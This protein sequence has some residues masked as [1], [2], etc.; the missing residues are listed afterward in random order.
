VVLHKW[1]VICLDNPS[2]KYEQRVY[3]IVL[4]IILE[5]ILNKVSLKYLEHI[6]HPRIYATGW[7]F[8]CAWW[9]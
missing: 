3:S 1:Q 5:H 9:I 6:C 4:I 2:L 7:A 8:W